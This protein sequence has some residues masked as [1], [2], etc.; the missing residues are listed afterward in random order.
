MQ[1]L[2]LWRT[3]LLWI[4][5]ISGVFGVLLYINT[6]CVL[7]VIFCTRWNWYTG[8]GVLHIGVYKSNRGYYRG[9][10]NLSPHP[11][12]YARCTQV[13]Y[14]LSQSV[15]FFFKRVGNSDIHTQCMYCTLL[16]YWPIDINNTRRKTELK[17]LNN[18]YHTIPSRI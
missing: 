18:N 3:G 6:I 12:V 4:Y 13:I 9:D 15:F 7:E 17:W 11:H 1:Q 10:R 2:G 5:T 16:C 14:R 8:F